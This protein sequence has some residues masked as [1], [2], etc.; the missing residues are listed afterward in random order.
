MTKTLDH[1]LEEEAAELITRKDRSD[2]AAIWQNVSQAGK[3]YFKISVMR[4]I[5][6]GATL[7]MFSNGYKGGDPKR[8][9]YYAYFKDELGRKSAPAA[10]IASPKDDEEIPF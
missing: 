8:P 5:P 7:L 10:A 6:T 1:R 2:V 9:D 3:T 4:D